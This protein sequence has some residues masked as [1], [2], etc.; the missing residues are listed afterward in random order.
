MKKLL[1]TLLVLPMLCSATECINNYLPKTGI[2]DQERLEILD[3]LYSPRS[4]AFLQEHNYVRP[5][6]KVLDVGSGA[7][8]MT[9]A[10]AHEVGPNGVIYSLD[11]D[12]A[13]LNLSKHYFV[14]KEISN[15]RFAHLP[16]EHL[17]TLDEK[18]DVIFVRFV[19]MHLKHPEA[20]L[21]EIHKALADNGVVIIEEP[22]CDDRV[23]LFHPYS[24]EEELYNWVATQQSKIA[25]STLFSIGQ[26][27]PDSL[28]FQGFEILATERYRPQLFTPTE[29]SLIWRSVESLSPAFV[30]NGITTEDEM[31]SIIERFRLLQEKQI[32]IDYAETIKVAARKKR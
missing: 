6:M 18:F 24:E 32:V 9:A 20:V 5:G 19:L 21:I 23:A 27:L 15:V 16:A 13:Q 30:Q 3:S 29:K 17:S 14:Q 2:E 22:N 31:Q 28:K 4:L 12:E 10:L 8:Y 25:Q 7:G 1:F 11:I 26:F